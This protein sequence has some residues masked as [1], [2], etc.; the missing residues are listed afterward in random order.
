MV[1]GQE[2]VQ[3]SELFVVHGIAPQPQSQEYSPTC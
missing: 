1:L 2:S 3:V